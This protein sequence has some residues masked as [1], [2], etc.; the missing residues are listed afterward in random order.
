MHVRHSLP[1]IMSTGLF[2]KKFKEGVCWWYIYISEITLGIFIFVTLPLWNK[3]SPLK[4]PKICA[5]PLGN[6]NTKNPRPLE[7]PHDFF[8][9]TPRKS[10]SFL[11]DSG[12]FA[13]FLQYPLKFHV[14]N[15][16]YLFLE[17]SSNRN[18]FG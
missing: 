14:L 8:L 1:P 5:T 17:W 11:I 15:T 2:Q 4:N 12:I 18:L 16:P 3:F 13:C 6:S 7:N 9:I 10:T